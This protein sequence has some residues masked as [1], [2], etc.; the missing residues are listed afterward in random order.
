MIHGTSKQRAADW[1]PGGPQL[2]Q[3][4]GTLVHR[5]VN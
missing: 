3:W 2:L 4:S 5:A 1:A